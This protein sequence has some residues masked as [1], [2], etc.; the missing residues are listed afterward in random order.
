LQKKK[1]KSNEDNFGNRI[2]HWSG[3]DSFAV[4]PSICQ[5][6]LMGYL[7]FTNEYWNYYVVR[8]SALLD[9]KEG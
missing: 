7:S 8:I 3:F 4:I 2:T 1:R 9:G 6:Y 5:R